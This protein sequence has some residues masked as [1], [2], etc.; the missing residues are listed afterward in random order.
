[1]LRTYPLHPITTRRPESLRDIFRRLEREIATQ[2]AG[3]RRHQLAVQPR[4][5]FAF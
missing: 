3:R 1:M 2:P 5:G 4:T